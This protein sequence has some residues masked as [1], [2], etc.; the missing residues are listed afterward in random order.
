MINF[1]KR[2]FNGDISLP[3]TYWIYGVL[4]GLILGIIIIPIKSILSDVLI[5]VYS[6]F[7]V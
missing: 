4:F 7:L 2:L 5:V 1:L 6:S 3:K